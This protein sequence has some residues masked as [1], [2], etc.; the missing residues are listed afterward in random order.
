MTPTHV[1][2]LTV[3]SQ[4]HLFILHQTI[5]SPTSSIRLDDNMIPCICYEFLSF[6]IVWIFLSW[7]P[8]QQ[9]LLIPVLSQ[10]AGQWAGQR[11]NK[12]QCESRL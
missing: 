3:E 5:L 12:T 4:E 10:S 6:I 7:L 9:L 1:T 8:R 11:M 2:S